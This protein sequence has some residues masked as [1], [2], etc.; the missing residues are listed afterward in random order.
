MATIGVF[1]SSSAAGWPRR[2]TRTTR[3]EAPAR[4]REV[5]QLRRR[6]VATAA[7]FRPGFGLAPQAPTTFVLTLTIV[8]VAIQF[9]PLVTAAFCLLTG[10]AGVWLTIEDL[11][12]IARSPTWSTGRR[13][14]RSSWWSS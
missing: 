6:A 4:Q 14:P 1:G 13:W 8:W 10:A 9:S 7:I 5:W 11:G 3:R 12:P 2:V